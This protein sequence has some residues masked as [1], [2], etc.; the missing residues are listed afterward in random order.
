[1][2]KVRALGGELTNGSLAKCVCHINVNV[3]QII[4][5]TSIWASIV[6][7][8]EKLIWG[9]LRFRAVVSE[10]GLSTCS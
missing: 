7:P 4:L 2:G 3:I 5:I 10:D 1:M 6:Q 9:S 8:N